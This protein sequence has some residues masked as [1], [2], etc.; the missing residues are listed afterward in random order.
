MEKS[1]LNVISWEHDERRNTTHLRWGEI[2]QSKSR[3]RERKKE[4]ADKIY[5]YDDV[6]FENG[7]FGGK[8]EWGKDVVARIVFYKR[9]INEERMSACPLLFLCIPASSSEM[10]ISYTIPRNS[11]SAHLFEEKR[12]SCFLLF[13]IPCPNLK[14][15]EQKSN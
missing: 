13:L 7:Q 12:K 4:N 11:S 5:R 3:S 6:G 14:R 2:P 10:F 15:E 1:Q 9:K 8:L